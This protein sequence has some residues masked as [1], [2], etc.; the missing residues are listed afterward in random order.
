MSADGTDVAAAL[1]TI[2]ENGDEAGLAEAIQDAFPGSHLV[3]LQDDGGMQVAMHTVGIERPLLA[4]ELSDGTLRYL[5][6]LAALLSPSPAPLLALNEPET[7]LHEDLIEPLARLVA[8]A[9]LTSQ[10]WLTTHSHILA[11]K[12]TELTLVKPI[13]LDKVDGA[14]V[15]AGRD[16]RIAFSADWDQ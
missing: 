2:Q 10:I 9:S 3:I 8:K 5:C 4:G 14:T 1:R 15:R 16:P 11:D 6:L 12:L 13:A 7:S